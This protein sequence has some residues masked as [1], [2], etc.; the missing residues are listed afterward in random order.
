MA[1]R[2]GAAP[3]CPDSGS[4]GVR[5]GWEIWNPE[6]SRPF[7]GLSGQQTR[8]SG[9]L[10]APDRSDVC[11]AL[12]LPSQVS[13][14]RGCPGQPLP[15]CRET[16]GLSFLRTG[17]C[18]ALC[19]LLTHLG[20]RPGRPPAH[21]PARRTDKPCLPSLWLQRRTSCPAPGGAS[22]APSHLQPGLLQGSAPGP[23]P[24]S[25]SVRAG[26]RR[27]GLQR[28]P[29]P[30]SPTS[31]GG[32]SSQTGS[33]DPEGP[34]PSSPQRGFPASSDPQAPPRACHGPRP[35][36]GRRAAHPARAG[37]QG[38]AEGPPPGT[39]S[40]RRCPADPLFCPMS[41]LSRVPSSL[42]VTISRQ[43]GHPQMDTTVPPSPTLGTRLGSPRL[44]LK[45]PHLS[46]ALS[47]WSPAC[48]RHPV[49]APELCPSS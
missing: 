18:P 48:A 3:R 10:G 45:C 42:R 40:A 30:C 5:G 12:P 49:S 33:T 7:W 15:N 31:R 20:P 13:S 4:E 38:P 43:T 41:P 44:S 22:P 26:C 17:T 23:Q 36:H 34:A 47:G 1:L 29:S 6:A 35:R 32:S 9:G 37:G 27:P 19:S 39:S 8:P 2:Q 25:G 24:V 46:G 21:L 28:A 11:R 16:A 14:G